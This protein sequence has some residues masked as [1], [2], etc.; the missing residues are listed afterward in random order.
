[1]PSSIFLPLLRIAFCSISVSTIRRWHRA[2]STSLISID[3]RT[4]RISLRL[5]S[6]EDKLDGAKH[7]RHGALYTT[8]RGRGWFSSMIGAGLQMKPSAITIFV[9]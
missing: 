6:I 5:L 7:Q 1:M 3:R 9:F 2:S 4:R 8:K